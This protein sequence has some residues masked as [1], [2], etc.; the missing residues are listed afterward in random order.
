[1]QTK[2]QMPDWVNWIAQDANGAW[3]GFEVQ[4][5]P[6]HDYWYENEV[7]RYVALGRGEPNPEW[8]TTLEALRRDAGG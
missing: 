5:L 6:A 7:G 3:W 2:P 4:P 1:M 8:E